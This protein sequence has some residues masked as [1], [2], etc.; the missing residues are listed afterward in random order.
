[1]S[2]FVDATDIE[3][4][5]GELDQPEDP[6]HPDI[7]VTEESG[8]TLSAFPSGLVVWEDFGGDRATP[9]HR[10]SVSRDELVVLFSALVRRDR[11]TIES[12]DWAPGYGA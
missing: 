11:R 12:G 8:W 10:A 4:L 2:P 7:A 3:A 9:R 1:M 5:V 6:E